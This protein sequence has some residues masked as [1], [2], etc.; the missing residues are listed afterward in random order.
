LAHI[1]SMMADA[2]RGAALA[3]GTE[4]TLENY[5]RYRD[6]ITLG[7]LEELVFAYAKELDAPRI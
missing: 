2:A 3:T 1:D 7:T 5:G 4:V 6:G